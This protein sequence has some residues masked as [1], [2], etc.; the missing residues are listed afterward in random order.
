MFTNEAK[1]LYG[2]STITSGNMDSA[3]SDW[4]NIYKGNP[5]WVDEENDIKTIKFAKAVCAETARLTCLDLGI[6]IDGGARA[7]YLQDMIDKSVFPRLR[8]W[9]EYGCACGTVILKPNGKGVD[10]V[11]P[12]RFKVTETDS[13]RKITGAI[14]QDGYVDGDN[15]YT[16]LEYHHF[17]RASVRMNDSEEYKEV[18]YYS[19]RNNAYVSKNV[20]ELGK[21]IELNNTKWSGLLPEVTI[22]KKNHE[23]LDGMLF[24][25]FRMPSAND[26]D[27][28]SPMG[29]A[30]F[31]E[32]IEEMKDLDISYSRNAYEID[33][34]KKIVL[35]DE[36]LVR[37]PSVRDSN[38]NIVRRKLELPKYVMNVNADD[39]KSFYQEIVPELQ[40]DKRIAGIN[41]QL[42][43]IGYKC[44]Y[45][46]G[47]FVFDQK[48]GMITATQV[49]SDDRRTIQMIKDI[50]DSL[51]Q[52]VKELLYAI[53]V[54]ADL[55]SLAPVSEYEVNYSFGDITYSYAED[56]AQWWQYV[57]QGK[58]PAWMY[59][60]KFE[61]MS[62]EEAK[63][64]QAELEEKEKKMLFDQG[65]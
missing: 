21:P 15:Y 3:V 20:G 22:T 31:S 37:L 47:Y 61:K 60:V 25:V 39:E 10:V 4:W 54:F 50:R 5:E 7:E 51:Q 27:I 11:T 13:N 44:G 58:V 48:T 40:T 56:K 41:N 46:N 16:K 38:G 9:V 2:V 1:S 62:E 63:A 23:Q 64:M 53:S 42:S 30:I 36:R 33:N 12:D 29:M 43:F 59:F 24:G 14:F 49:E 52:A 34:S 32:A 65:E 28:D 26:I 18:V 57:T 17:L 6:V 35:A 8:N 45:S 55:Y 19:I